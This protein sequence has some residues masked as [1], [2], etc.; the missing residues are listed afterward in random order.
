M[1]R[2]VLL[3]AHGSRDPGWATP[4]DRLADAVRAGLPGYRIELAFLESMPPTFD[5]AIE[6]IAGF[7]ESQVTVAPLFLAQGGHVRD[8]LPRLIAA[9]EERHPGL[10]FRL[11]PSLGD[12]PQVLNAITAWVIESQTSD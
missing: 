6:R 9:A 11:L 7:G 2:S 4:F 10:H 3:F 8:D 5:Q 12:A 1:N